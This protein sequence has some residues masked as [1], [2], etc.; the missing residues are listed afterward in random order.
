MKQNEMSLMIGV[1]LQKARKAK[2]LTQEQLAEKCN[3]STNHISAIETGYS[4]FSFSLLVLI[5][6]N[7]DITPN[8]LFKDF[9]A[10]KRDSLELVNRNVL[11]TYLKLNPQNKEFIDDTIYKVYNL[12][13]HQHI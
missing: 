6:N 5:C 7:L 13:K 3:I 9:I 8:Y 12:Q 2:G 10:S 4:N 11:L 1:R